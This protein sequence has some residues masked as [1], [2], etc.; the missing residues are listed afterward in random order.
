[1]EGA[2]PL[3]QPF[4]VHRLDSRLCLCC[5]HKNFRGNEHFSNAPGTFRAFPSATQQGQVHRQQQL[6]AKGLRLAAL[7]T[8]RTLRL[9]FACW[10]DHASGARRREALLRRAA[11]ALRS[12]AA[13]AA[14]GAW[15]AWVDT[16]HAQRM[17]LQAVSL[18]M[19][20]ASAV[21]HTALA[22]WRRGVAEIKQERRAEQE[23]A[24]QAERVRLAAEGLVAR[25]LTRSLLRSTANAFK[26]WRAAAARARAARMLL[27][28]A[29][30]AASSRTAA[31]SL[32]QWASYARGRRQRAVAYARVASRVRRTRLAQAVAQWAA[33]AAQQ[34]AERTDIDKKEEELALKLRRAANRISRMQVVAALAGWQEAA[35]ARRRARDRL[36]RAS[37]LLLRRRELLTMQGWHAWAAARRYRRD[38][39]SKAIEYR[40]VKFVSAVFRAWRARPL[41]P[42]PPPSAAAHRSCISLRARLPPSL[43]SFS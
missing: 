6:R 36:R 41:L 30:A 26:A 20:V 14:F 35:V 12:R 31:S 4:S 32:L 39:V 22:A 40:N 3:L 17:Q 43:G 19:S 11:A 24:A 29:V 27:R 25:H 38:T 21:L 28:R 15:V 18:R 7:A 34:R 37:L 2:L 23:A 8:V 33:A 1:M 10:A 42:A 13:R 5:T 9:A 16:V